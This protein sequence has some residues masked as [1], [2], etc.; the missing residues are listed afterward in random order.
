[1]RVLVTGASGL[2]GSA[3]LKSLRTDGQQAIALV[4]RPARDEN[5]IEWD[6]AAVNAQPFEGADAVVHL[7]GES[8]VS[9][10]WS[11]ES[12]RRITESRVAVT[13]NVA[14]S[15]AA[16][17]RK[18]PVLVTAS[19]VGAYG[20]RGDEVLT[21]NS[22]YGSG[23]VAQLARDWEAANEPAARAGVRTVQ[24]RIGVVVS[25]DGGA[26]PRMALPFRLGLGGRVGN[27]RQ[28]MSWITV[29]D[30]VRLVR[31]AIE[32]DNLS[33]PVNA[34]APNPGTNAEFTRVLARVLRRPAIFPVPAFVLRLLAGEV[35]DE[36]L[37]ASNRA[38]PEKALA[39]GFRFE[40]PELEAALRHAFTRPSRR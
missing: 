11:A 3:L 6:P 22:G 25:G 32:N 28:W 35:A 5:E 17:E 38:V 10:R 16:A 36:L 2:I 34:V 19:G 24:L 4:R 20:N 7:A 21:E 14:E 40:Y 18:P 37:L 26:L 39:A 27:G 12:K 8:L 15:I 23:F 30:V 1:M 29:D 31:F 33:G 13:R 9:G